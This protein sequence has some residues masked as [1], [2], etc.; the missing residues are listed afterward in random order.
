MTISPF[1]MGERGIDDVKETHARLRAAGP[2]VRIDAPAGGSAWIVTDDALARQVLTDPRFT[3]D[4]AMA[5]AAWDPEVAALEPPASVRSS[6]TTLDG[7]A[8]TALRKAHAPLLSARGLGEHYDRMVELATEL[9]N[10]TPPGEPVDLAADFATRFPI[11]VLC[12]LMGVVDRT[13]AAMTACRDMFS[14][15]PDVSGGAMKAFLELADAALEAEHDRLAHGLQDRVPE[16][17]DG[18]GLRYLLFVLVFA[19]QITM[20]SA[21]SVL[22]AHVVEDGFTGTD[23]RAV[24]AFVQDLLRKHPPAPFTLWRFTTVPVELGDV[25][26]P[27]NAPVLVDLA[28]ITTD[29][30]RPPGPDLVFGAGPH[31]CIGAQLALLELR[32]VTEVLVREFPDARLAVPFTELRQTDIG[33]TQ[34]SRVPS[35]PVV[36]RPKA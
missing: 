26:L 5:P 11:Q 12:E 27:A 30:N 36:L 34:G 13:D 20:D 15:D 16:D 28:G 33:G 32:A 7:P 3:K 31:Y 14:P 17:I 1:E 22:V 19:G 25:A 29:P 21:L 35:L 4:P 9:L 18:A 24:D 2:V 6:L 8:H 23:R 10:A